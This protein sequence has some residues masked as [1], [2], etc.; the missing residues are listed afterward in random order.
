VAAVTEVKT[1]KPKVESFT[2]ELA[3][4]EARD[5]QTYIKTYY[6]N[7]GYGV[8]YEKNIGLYKTIQDGLDGKK[9][10]GYAY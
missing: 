1:A 10:P 6:Q 5:I 7:K 9:T 4:H 2:V 3:P 8:G